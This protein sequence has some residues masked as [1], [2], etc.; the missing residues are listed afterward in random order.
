M[1]ENDTHLIPGL[2]PQFKI[3]DMVRKTWGNNDQGRVTI[4]TT[5]KTKSVYIYQV[6]FEGCTSMFLEKELAKV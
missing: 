3:G 2:A 6:Q 1:S 5:D 4:V